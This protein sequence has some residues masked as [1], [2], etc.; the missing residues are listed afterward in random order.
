LIIFIVI[1]LVVIAL[2]DAFLE[3][4]K[5]G[6]RLANKIYKEVMQK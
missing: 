2:I 3:N 4:T 6:R 1:F 5:H